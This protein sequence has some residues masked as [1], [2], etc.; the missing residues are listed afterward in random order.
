M[1]ALICFKL[2]RLGKWTL[3]FDV[4]LLFEA[5]PCGVMKFSG[6]LGELIICHTKKKVV[7]TND[8]KIQTVGEL[9]LDYSCITKLFF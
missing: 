1:A 8:A 5:Q 7:S 6:A 4:R 9:C 2:T 3:G